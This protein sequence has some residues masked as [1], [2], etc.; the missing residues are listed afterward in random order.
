MLK[1]THLC[2]RGPFTDKW[3]YQEN[4]LTK[5][6]KKLGYAVSVITSSN[7]YDNNGVLIS[8]IRKEYINEDGVK[9]VR[10]PF[11]IGKSVNSKLKIYQWLM[12]KP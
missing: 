6:Q 3:T 10:L 9:I 11:K 8:D 1:V 7:R 5:Y 12:S 4:L 2:L